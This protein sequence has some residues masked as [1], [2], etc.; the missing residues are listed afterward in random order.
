MIIINYPSSYK[1]KYILFNINFLGI[2][3]NYRQELEINNKNGLRRN[4]LILRTGYNERTLDEVHE[5]QYYYTSSK[6]IQNNSCTEK[7]I[8]ELGLSIFG[9]GPK[10]ILTLKSCVYNSIYIDIINKQ[11]KIKGIPHM[12][13][14]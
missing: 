13:L 9:F 6:Y 10:A 7:N 4:S 5:Y 8:L 11:M 12:Y 14:L 1:A 2:I 3:I